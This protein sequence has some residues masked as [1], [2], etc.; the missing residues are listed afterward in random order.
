MQSRAKVVVLVSAS[1]TTV[2]LGGCSG[3][4]GGASGPA[5]A[6]SQ[7]AMSSWSMLE[8]GADYDVVDDVDKLVAATG[9]EHTIRGKVVSAVPGASYKFGPGDVFESAYLTVSVSESDIPGLET[10]SVEVVKPSAVS[11]EDLASVLVGD[12][13]A[14]YLVKTGPLF[15]NV[16][17]SDLDDQPEP[18]NLYTL[19]S[20]I[21]GALVN[22]GDSIV[23]LTTND[24]IL[25]NSES[26]SESQLVD[27]VSASLP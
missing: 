19:S 6:P 27:E 4:T 23:S 22:R 5:P 26:T 14:V 8:V 12:E 13:E 1:A 11:A 10:A 16:A 3:A 9:T 7:E 24:E 20:Q 18:K 25:A 21:M 2:I 17:V 15:E